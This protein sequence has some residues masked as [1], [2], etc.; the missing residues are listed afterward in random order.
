MNRSEAPILA[1]AAVLVVILLVGEAYI[2]TLDPDDLYEIGSVRTGD[3]INYSI[4]SGASNEYDVVISENGGFAP[5]DTLYIYYDEKYVSNVEDVWQP[6]GAKPLTQSYYISEL[7]YQLENRG[8]TERSSKSIKTLDAE[9]LEKTLSG[10]LDSTSFGKGLVIISGALPHTVYS[11][12]PDDLVLRWISDG[13]TLYWAGNLL[14]AWYSTTDDLV[15]VDGYQ[16]LFFGADCL[17]V[18][19]IDKAASDITEN[20]YRYALSLM[21]NRVKYGVNTSLID[22]ALGI[23]Y[24]ENEYSSIAFV[25]HGNGMI[26]VIAGDYSNYQRTDLAQIISS[27]LCYSSTIIGSDG[28][29]VTREKIEGTISVEG[30]TNISVYIYLGGY[31]TVRGANMFFN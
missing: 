18:S 26:S 31:Y 14:G 13:G 30:H 17:N 7:K 29:K 8:F 15:P 24:T 16:D 25:K 27:G 10:D 23:G 4:T 3:D 21:N 5:I 28:G 9:E 11:G 22:G 12:D 6:I 1:I 2:Y 20:D 19:D